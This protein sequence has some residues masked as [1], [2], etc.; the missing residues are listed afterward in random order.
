MADMPAAPAPPPKQTL[1]AQ[2]QV[3]S[4]TF[5]TLTEREIAYFLE[6]RLAAVS[7]QSSLG[8]HADGTRAI[9]SLIG[10]WLISQAGAAVGRRRLVNLARSDKTLLKSVGGVAKL[11]HAAFASISVTRRAS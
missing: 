9:K 5:L 8:T 11:I 3:D 1:A 10:V 7:H 4:A 6:R 2:P